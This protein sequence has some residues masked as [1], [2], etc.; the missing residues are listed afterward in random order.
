[1][2]MSRGNSLSIE[3]ANMPHGEFLPSGLNSPSSRLLSPME[4]SVLTPALGF[5]RTRQG[6]AKAPVDAAKLPALRLDSATLWPVPW[7]LDPCKRTD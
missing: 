6:R 1:M 3:Y 7:T 4:W 5:R 2:S